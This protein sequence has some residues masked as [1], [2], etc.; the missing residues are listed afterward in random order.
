MLKQYS[1]EYTSDDE[2]TRL[3]EK[4][5]KSV[6]PMECMPCVSNVTIV[7]PNVRS[8]VVKQFI[9]L[10]DSCLQSVINTLYMHYQKN[11]RQHMMKHALCSLPSQR[12]LW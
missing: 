7:L 9:I 1:E 3:W 2:M 4:V 11:N 8:V 5:L 6:P 12:P 10:L